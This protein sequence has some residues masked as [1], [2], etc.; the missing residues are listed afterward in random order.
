MFGFVKKTN[1]DAEIDKNEALTKALKE[2]ESAVLDLQQKLEEHEKRYAE[3][4]LS[5]QYK[6]SLDFDK[7]TN[8]LANLKSQFEKESQAIREFKDIELKKAK[9]DL[10]EKV[11][12]IRNEELVKIENL[13]KKHSEEIEGIQGDLDKANKSLTE[14]TKE[15][16]ELSSEI[17]RK[18]RKLK[19]LESHI[20]VQD[21]ISTVTSVSQAITGV[22]SSEIQLKID[23]NKERQKNAIKS[24]KAWKAYNHYYLDNSLSAGKA[25]QRRLA[26]FLLTAFNSQTDNIISLAKKGNFHACHTKIEKWF[27]KINKLGEDHHIM[28]ER[29]YLKLRLEEL[30]V[31]VEYHLQ[32]EF[33]K[34]EERY[35]NESIREEKRVQKEIESFVKSRE[36]EE[37]SYKSEIE[38]ATKE[39]K[40]SSEAEVESLKRLI[41]DLQLKL[42]RSVKEKE[43]ALSLAQLTRS[44]HVYIISNE[45]SFGRGVYKIGM[46]RRLDPMDRVKELGD[47]SVPFFFDVHGIIHSD[48]APGLEREL[49]KRFEEHRVNKENYRREFFRVPIEVIENAICEVH[50]EV[51]LDRLSTREKLE[52]GVFQDED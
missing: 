16:S 7:L 52:E 23:E 4:T 3:L 18:K 12:S 47:A 45:G 15:L 30:R 46:T 34:E 32:K 20:E 2:K 36:K 11:E 10:E 44:G 51:S 13:K 48:D 40:E 41:D 17:K 27:E 31:V 28:I 42:E 49:H 24:R 25:Q 14:T 37:K 19:E 26:K 39:L 22:N 6:R 9:S 29:Q 1:L 21:E 5:E 43:R 8:D 50:G 35:I 38:R 33:E